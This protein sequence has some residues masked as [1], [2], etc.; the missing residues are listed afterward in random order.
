MREL[1]PYFQDVLRILSEVDYNSAFIHGPDIGERDNQIGRLS[2]RLRY[3]NGST[4]AVLITADCSDEY[5]IW[6]AYALHYQQSTSELLF[7]YD[8]A[9]HHHELPNFP[10][11]LHVGP[12]PAIVLPYGPP[13]PRRVAAAI[14]WHL[15]NPGQRW[16][17][18]ASQHMSYVGGAGAKNAESEVTQE[19]PAS[20]DVAPGLYHLVLC[21]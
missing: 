11:H 2:F 12:D 21:E 5:P 16:H 20:H 7:R 14:R 6:P 1:V 15:D 10:H 4:L 18:D 3:S 13:S 8:N 9:P 19:M 17:P